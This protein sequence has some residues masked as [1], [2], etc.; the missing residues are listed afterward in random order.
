[1]LNSSYIELNKDSYRKNLDFLRKILHP[2]TRFSSVVKGNAYGHGIEHFVPLAES[3][4]VNHFSVH[5][6]D[7]ALEVRK[8]SPGSDVMIMGFLDNAEIAWAVENDIEFFVFEFDR[9]E[10]TINAAKMLQR[11]ARVHFELETGMHRTGFEPDE[12]PRLMDIIRN[13]EAE[14]DFYGLCTHFAGAESINNFVRVKSQKRVYNATVRKF[15]KEG[16]EPRYQHTCCSAASIRMPEMHLDLVRIGILQYGFWPSHETFIEYLRKNDM[17]VEPLHRVIQWKSKVMSLKEVSMGEYV[18]Y[19][20]TFLAQRDTKI[21]IIPVGY[22]HG[23]SRILSNQGR[24]IIRGKRLPVIGI[25]NMNNMA[26]DVTDLDHVDK[27]DEV[28]LIGSDGH[29]EITV[30][31]FGELSTQL[32]YELLTRLPINI[33]RRV[34]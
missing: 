27:G 21:A 22:S 33:P 23:F 6:A 11:R 17:K 20:S 2:N 4:G 32:N 19:G 5:S 25:V 28:I 29:L 12:I 18:G 8:A 24:V 10:N 13:H 26:V 3:F 16:L 34:V 9:L 7:E 14:L 30:E 15:K 31:S 1:M